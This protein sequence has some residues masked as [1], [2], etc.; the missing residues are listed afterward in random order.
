V[1]TWCQRPFVNSR[2]LVG[3]EAGT[4]K[5]KGYLYIGLDGRTYL[6]SQLAFFWV[7]GRWARGNVGLK[8][9][10]PRNLRGDNLVEMRSIPGEPGS[11]TKDGFIRYGR[12]YRKA[13]P[14]A[15][16]GYGFKR[17]YDID[18]ATYQRMFVEQNGVCAI[19]Q[20]PESAKSPAGDVKWLSVDHDHATKAVR[21]LLCSGC[22]HTL[23]H[24]GDDSAVL[25]AA[26]D[27]L[28]RFAA[29]PLKE[30]A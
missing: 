11:K 29:E 28:D 1:F 2:V 23:G 19:C 5:G 20:K 13:N 15:F 21:G 6:A 22:N 18:L 9:K 26:A 14:G 12:E 10:D 24:A 27:Y 17:Y 3:D 4:H 16:R 8:D 30:T 7:H 25:R